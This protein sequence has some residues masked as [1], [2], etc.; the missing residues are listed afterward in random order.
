MRGHPPLIL[1]Q[2]LITRFSVESADI[3]LCVLS[4]SDVTTGSGSI[5]YPPTIEPLIKDDTFILFNKA[6]LLP[7]TSSTPPLRK[8]SW[9]VS[10]ETGRGLQTFMEGL[11][12]ALQERY[13]WLKASFP[14]GLVSLT[15]PVQVRCDE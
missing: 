15:V 5:C 7:Q 9:F 8:N 12:I 6:D 13:G 1:L 11:A 2:E 4:S 3:S 10:L 14:V